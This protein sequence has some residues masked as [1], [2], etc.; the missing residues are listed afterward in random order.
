MIFYDKFDLINNETIYLKII[1]KNNGTIDELPYYYF[2]IYLKTDN[3]QVGKISIRI[4]HNKHSYY[5]GNIGYEINKSNRGEKLSLQA[6]Q[7]VI[8]VAKYHGMKYLNLTCDDAN[9]ASQKII[10]SLGAT[11]IET[12][13]PP[14][15]YIFYYDGMPSYK[16]YRLNI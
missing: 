15:D 3:S 13:V 12:T 9:V 11:Y 10:E 14:K 5:N 4:G 2:D 16:I 1:D 6:C 8:P 7:L